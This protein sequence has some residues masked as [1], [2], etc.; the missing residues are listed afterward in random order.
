MA[1]V[2]AV[3]LSGPGAFAQ[4]GGSVANAT[5]TANIADGAPV[6]F[7]QQFTNSTPVVYFYGEL[8]GL[9][10]QTVTF[11]WSLEGKRMQETAVQVT[12]P[13][14][15]AWSKMNM[16]EQ[17]TGN[18]TVEILDGKGRTIEQRNFAFSP[19]L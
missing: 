8:L 3:A 5:F 18:W 1:L 12:S 6:D 17:W 10:G 2:F 19:P 15:P 11:L 4:D 13:R 16:Q 9:N 7:R 14:Q